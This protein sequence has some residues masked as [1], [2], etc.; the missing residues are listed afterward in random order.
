[1][2]VGGRAKQDARAELLSRATQ[3]QV[4]STQ[5]AHR[6]IF[7]ISS[8]FFVDF[9]FFVVKKPKTLRVLGNSSCVA[10]LTGV[11]P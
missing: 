6:R 11:L 8:F 9:V 4:P 3:E 7:F 2:D 5:R 1:M 10:L